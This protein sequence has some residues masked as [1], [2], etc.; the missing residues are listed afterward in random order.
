MCD[1]VIGSPRSTFIA[2]HREISHDIYCDSCGERICHLDNSSYDLPSVES[3]MEFYG[4]VVTEGAVA[5][6]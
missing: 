6:S 3:I 5:L 1:H 2:D 4:K